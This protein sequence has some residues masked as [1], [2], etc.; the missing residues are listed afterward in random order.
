MKFSSNH[1]NFNY[2]LSIDQ[3]GAISFLYAQRHSL[4]LHP[5]ISW[6]NFLKFEDRFE[7]SL[8]ALVTGG[9]QALEVCRQQAVD[10]DTGELHAA[11]R[12][13]CRQGRRDLFVNVLEHLD[14]EDNE[15]M[16]ALF[17]ALKYE[18]PVDWQEDLVSLL[19]TDDEQ[20]C[21]L[22]A[23][24][25]G[26]R[27]IPAGRNLVQALQ[28]FQSAPLIWAVGRLR[29][30][31]AAS[32]LLPALRHDDETVCS[33]A[34]L[35]LLR[36]GE[37]QALD[38]CREISKE[39]GWAVIPLALGGGKSAVPVVLAIARSEAISPD[40]LLALGLL[41]ESS[42]APFLLEKLGGKH[43]EAAAQALNLLTGAELYERAFIP[44]EVDEDEL[45]PDELEAYK[46]E[47]KAPTKPD[48][49][50]YG[51]W[52]TRLSQNP[53]E[54]SNWW[55]QNSHLFQPGIRYRNGTPF[56]PASLLENLQHEKTPYKIRQLA[57]EELVIR[58]DVDFPF[59]A[60]MR[61][62]E[63]LRILDDMARW[64][65]ANSGR[66]QSGQWYFAGKIAPETVPS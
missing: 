57:Y 60:D 58:Y 18:L 61:V 30:Q 1:A 40:T 21:A 9:E 36:L 64:V 32:L 38:H 46:K 10:G 2:S 25:V 7:A 66:F 31:S 51:E 4:L 55:E 5:P 6:N 33:A 24:V 53:A 45:F 12:V 63:Q 16:Q 54:W 44:E 43:A 27:R 48:G 8:D 50:P 65:D 59:E 34:A 28:R 52:V 22:V 39:K 20:L 11:V 26:Y 13:F 19:Q 56:S 62:V 15:K 29:E 42:A 14:P 17:D 23:T 37:R 3:L 49:T 41:G 35:T 47:G